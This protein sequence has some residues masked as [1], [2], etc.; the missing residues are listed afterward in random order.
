MGLSGYASRW[1]RCAHWQ[2]RSLV[3]LNRVTRRAKAVPYR[4]PKARLTSTRHPIF[5]SMTDVE[6]SWRMEAK[7]GRTG[8]D[9]PHAGPVSRGCRRAAVKWT[10]EVASREGDKTGRILRSERHTGGGPM[11]QQPGGPVDDNM[12]QAVPARI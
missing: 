7:W 10:D 3:A 9:A 4:P 12:G 11:G 1:S 8:R 6:F 2:G 5:R